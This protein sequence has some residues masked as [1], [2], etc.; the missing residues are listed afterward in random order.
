MGGPTHGRWA[1]RERGELEKPT[2]INF[3]ITGPRTT[4]ARASFRREAFAKSWRRE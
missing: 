3:E 2:K 1:Q 4:F